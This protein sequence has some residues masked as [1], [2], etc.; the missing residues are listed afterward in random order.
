MNKEK[1][2]EKG[3]RF[4]YCE[5]SVVPEIPAVQDVMF[6]LRLADTDEY[7]WFAVSNHSTYV[8]NVQLCCFAVAYDV[9]GMRPYDEATAR[10]I[11]A[12]AIV[13][14]CDEKAKQTR[15]YERA[16]EIAE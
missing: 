13:A 5:Y 8:R 4:D 15:A 6:A 3:I 16:I 2:L 11:I 9:I 14:L 1:L 7:Y 10:K 12:R